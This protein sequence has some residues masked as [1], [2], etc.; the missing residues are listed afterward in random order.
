MFYPLNHSVYKDSCMLCFISE[1]K[2]KCWKFGDSFKNLKIQ[3]LVLIQYIVLYHMLYYSNY[4][5]NCPCVSNVGGKIIVLVSVYLLHDKRKMMTISIFS[6]RA[7]IQ[8]MLC[9]KILNSAF[10]NILNSMFL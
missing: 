5:T 7:G 10:Y 9:H 6:G 3:I 4:R 2:K 1:R 8:N